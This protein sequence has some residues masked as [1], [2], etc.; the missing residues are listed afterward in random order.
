MNTRITRR[1]LLIAIAVTATACRESRTAGAPPQHAES[2]TV[3]LV[4]D[5]MI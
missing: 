5:G 4:V 1:E 2:A 3:T